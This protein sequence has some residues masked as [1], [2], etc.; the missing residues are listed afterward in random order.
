MEE[1]VEIGK[2]LSNMY[3]IKKKELSRSNKRDLKV[4]DEVEFTSRG[5]LH[6]GKIFKMAITKAH[7]QTTRLGLCSVPFTMLKKRV[8]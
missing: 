8:A 5:V 1:L 7:V 4:G 3:D 2:R 6:H